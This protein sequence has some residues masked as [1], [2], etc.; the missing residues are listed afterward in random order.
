MS[1]LRRLE[2]PI[3]VEHIEGKIGKFSAGDKTPIEF[4]TPPE[5]RGPEGYLSPED[6]QF[7]TK[8]LADCI[9]IH[10]RSQTSARI[11]LK[12]IKIRRLPSAISR[13]I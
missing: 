11:L 10:S 7:G 9:K 1:E 6:D 12:M 4:S 8:L 5:F 2:Y 3:E 13:R